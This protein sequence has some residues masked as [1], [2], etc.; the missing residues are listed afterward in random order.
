MK[1]ESLLSNDIPSPR[2]Y[3]GR[4]LKAAKSAQAARGAI[5]EAFE[6]FEHG[7]VDYE[8]ELRMVLESVT[9]LQYHLVRLGDSFGVNALSARL[10]LTATNPDVQRR[11]TRS[12]DHRQ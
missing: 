7:E 9:R 11:R 5:L 10:G 12:K 6:R 1:K 8:E 2:G 4:F 3:G